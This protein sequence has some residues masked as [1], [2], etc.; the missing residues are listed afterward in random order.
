[1]K[2]TSLSDETRDPEKFS[3]FPL[4]DAIHRDIKTAGF[5]TPTPIQAA[6]IPPALAGKDVI[7]LAQTGTG[8]TAAFALPIIERIAH[9]IEMCALVLAPT[10]ELA[11]QIAVMFKEL[12]KTSGIRV[13][14]T[15]GGTPISEDH[16][17]LRSWPNVL[18][19]TPGR[20]IDHIHSR[21]VHLQDIEVLVVDEADRMHD[22]GFIPQIQR[23]IEVLPRD[24]QTLMLTATM[25]ADVERIARRNMRNAVRIQVGRRSAPP[26]RAEQQLFLLSEDE[27]PTLLMK[28]L[29]RTEGRVLVFLRTKTGVNHLARVLSSRRYNAV[30]LHS[31]R[32]QSDRDEALA[33][34]RNG[35]YRILIATDIA[36]R[37]LDIADIEHVVNY[38][39]PRSSEDY[40][41]RIGRTA[42]VDAAGL[43]TTFVTRADRRHVTKL[44][45]ML[46][47][48]LPIHRVGAGD[49]TSKTTARTKA[50][51]GRR[52]HRRRSG[53]RRSQGKTRVSG[54]SLR[55][56]REAP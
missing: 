32:M 42:R 56:G 22:L 20:L 18:V 6:F 10:R 30:R 26:E 27:K 12:G 28:L 14:V 41:H 17:A 50:K 48:K 36:A 39:F 31:G 54:S 1:M 24:R 29:D 3:D 49:D 40:V 45:A 11:Q 46:G 23:I 52:S 37:G 34:F 21:T 5:E 43:A 33:G 2:G 35:T 19:A 13:A 15:V 53:R 55:S 9:R 25:P 16:K 38:D 7:G 47:E 8:K 44:E 51:E 4:K